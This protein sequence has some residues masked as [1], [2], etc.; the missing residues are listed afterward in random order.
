VNDPQVIDPTQV[1]A[2][3]V[4]AA[5]LNDEGQP[6][7]TGLVTVLT[8]L[9]ERLSVLEAAVSAIQAYLQLQ[10]LIQA[11]NQVQTPPWLAN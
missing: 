6:T 4:C 10:S 2:K 5:L 11:Q 1:A 3:T 7:L 8:D 9:Q